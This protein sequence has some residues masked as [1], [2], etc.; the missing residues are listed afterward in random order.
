MF[1]VYVFERIVLGE[2]M[3]NRLI[4]FFTLIFLFLFL[5]NFVIAYQAPLE[6]FGFKGIILEG[7]SK[8]ECV[9]LSIDIVELNETGNGILSLNAKFEGAK[10]NSSFVSVKINEMKEIVIWPEN[11]SDNGYARVFVPALAKQKTDLE[12]CLISGGNSERT[13]LLTSSYIGLYDTP[14]LEIKTTAPKS[15]ILGEKA[16]MKIFLKNTGS[17][18]TNYFVQFVSKDLRTLLNITNFDIIDGSSS[19]SGVIKAGEVQEFN[20][21][22]IPGKISGY[23]LPSS[24]VKFT[25][26]FG[27]EQIIASEHPQLSV[28]DPKQIKLNLTSFEMD[29]KLKLVILVENNWDEPFEGELIINPKDLIV[30]STQEIQLGP[31]ATKEIVLLTNKLLPGKYNFSA[32]IKDTNNTYFSNSVSYSVKNDDWSLAIILAVFGVICAAIV[33]F[34]IN[35]KN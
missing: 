25:N 19:A 18:D 16:H 34:V 31:K 1:L 24:I 35:T 30:S 33:F 3:T 17:M 13:E 12:I 20:F 28:L 10:A 26:I 6:D 27:E 22:I 29:D 8:K 5:A 21:S 11:F 2:I 32:T 15:I 14:V 4:K 9:P 7:E 23:N